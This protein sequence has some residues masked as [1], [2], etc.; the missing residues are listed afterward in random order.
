MSE[1]PAFHAVSVHALSVR[2]ATVTVAGVLGSIALAPACTFGGL[3]NYTIEECKP[4]AKQ[5]DDVCDRLNRPP[6]AGTPPACTTYQCDPKLLRCVEKTRDDDRDGDPARECGGTD[7]DDADPERSGKAKEVCDRVD[8]DCNGM[9]DEGVIQPSTER[10][11]AEANLTASSEPILIGADVNRQGALAAF[12]TKESCIQFVELQRGSGGAGAECAVLASDGASIAPHQPFPL[13]TADGAGAALVGASNCPTGSLVYRF[14]NTAKLDLGCDPAHPVAL[15][16][17]AFMPANAN[18]N[19]GIITWYEAP[20]GDRAEPI[21]G[22]ATVKPARLAVLRSD[23]LKQLTTMPSPNDVLFSAETSL[24]TRPA[25]MLAVEGA[26]GMLVATPLGDDMGV[27]FF[28]PPTLTGTALP[29]PVR[30]PEL[31]GARAAALAMRVDDDLVHVALATEVGCA[32]KASV[33]LSL[34]TL[35]KGGELRFAPPIEV[36]PEQQ[37]A[38]A[39]SVAW[40]ANRGEWWA[41]FIDAAQ[42]VVV[43]RYTRDGQPIGD[44]VTVATKSF[45]LGVLS[46][47]ESLFGFTPTPGAFVEVP[48]DC[49]R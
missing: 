48:L 3:A 12:V 40:A 46:A 5:A 35:T 22:C 34:G 31:R 47:G 1:P 15:P 49:P 21:T 18:A 27:F 7:C 36:A 20:F 8:N 28:S 26:Q 14:G 44:A 24:A 37:I 17:V 25:A 9:V 41:S 16:A 6:V 13:K 23:N 32:P 19:S 42:H 10:L 11:I 30:I 45:P 4:A 38:T 2:A 39:P 29:P 43:R 33:K